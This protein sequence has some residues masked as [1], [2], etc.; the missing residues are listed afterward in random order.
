MITPSKYSLQVFETTEALNKTAAEF[1]IELSKKSI[2]ERGRFII[3][4][5]GGET[6]KKVYSLLSEPPFK[7]QIQW[8]KTFIFWGDERC[9]P[10]TDER[11]NGHQAKSILLD[12]VDIPLSN[13]HFIPVNLTPSQA[14]FEY[15]KKIKNFFG[16]EPPRFDLVLLGLGENGHTASLFPGTKVIGEQSEGIREVYVEEEKMFRVTMT[17]PLIN[18]AYNILFLVTGENKADILKKILTTT[19]TPDIYPA[20]LIKPVNGDLFW[21]ADRAAASLII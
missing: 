11:N 18:E 16:E 1:I 17:A 9:V 8:K 21:F 15:E 4:L 13:I 2:A 12:K 14:A 10:F 20:Q 19:Y 6:P 3:S 5:S 7:D